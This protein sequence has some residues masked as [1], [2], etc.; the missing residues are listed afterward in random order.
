MKSI[1]TLGLSIILVTTLASQAHAAGCA[2]AKLTTGSFGTKAVRVINNCGTSIRYDV[3]VSTN[4]K[5]P[6]NKAS[7]SGFVNAGRTGEAPLTV[8]A[9]AKVTDFQIEVSTDGSYPNNAQCF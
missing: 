1:S 8:P 3:C 2:R 7:A 6:N 9:A 4:E 5:W